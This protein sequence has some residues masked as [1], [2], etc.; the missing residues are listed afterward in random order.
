[1]GSE[2]EVLALDR[3]AQ[4]LTGEFTDLGRTDIGRVVEDCLLQFVDSPIRTYV[5]LL[6]ERAARARLQR[7]SPARVSQTT[8]VHSPPAQSFQ[9][10][11]AHGRPWAVL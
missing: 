6:V 9:Q 5:P 11:L 2:Q 3:V 8:L 4:R 10:I 7:M 1:M